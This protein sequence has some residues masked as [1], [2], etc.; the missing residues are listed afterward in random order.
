MLIRGAFRVWLFIFLTAQE[1]EPKEGAVSRLILRVAESAGARGNSLALRQSA[2][3]IRPPRRCSARD[4]GGKTLN[5]R[6]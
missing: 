6:Q 4:K 2:R 1:N 3:F 5:A